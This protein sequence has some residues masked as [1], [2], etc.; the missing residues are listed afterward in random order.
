[1]LCREC[2][3]SF[4]LAVCCPMYLVGRLLLKKAN[5]IR[6]DANFC[7]VQQNT[8]ILSTESKWYGFVE[9]VI[10]M[11]QEEKQKENRDT[12]KLNGF[13]CVLYMYP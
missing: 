7:M 3:E 10:V 4:M 1:M 2:N 9:F 11:K 5:H 13:G 6:V 12:G 8:Y